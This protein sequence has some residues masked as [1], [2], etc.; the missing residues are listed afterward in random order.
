MRT[1]W[2]WTALLRRLHKY[3]VKQ[4]REKIILSP[5]IQN[6]AI[7]LPPGLQSTVHRLQICDLI[8]KTPSMRLAQTHSTNRPKRRAE[9][10]QD[11]HSRRSFAECFGVHSSKEHIQL[12]MYKF[13]LQTC[14][15]FPLDDSASVSTPS[16]CANLLLDL[17]AGST[18]FASISLVHKLSLFYIGIDLSG[19]NV[20]IPDRSDRL[21]CD[22][23]RSSDLQSSTTLPLR[24]DSVDVI[25]SISFL[26]WLTASHKELSGVI[27]HFFSEIHRILTPVGHC[28]IQFYPH[29]IQELDVVCQ[30]MSTLSP[31][32]SGCRIYARPVSDR[33]VKIFL[34]TRRTL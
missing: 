16:I 2:P 9:S 1:R 14:L 22:L 6:S 12:A 11:L 3:E 21:I 30:A 15:N 32:L 20:S 25:L 29:S 34:Y 13:A 18:G 24:D 5:L 27:D 19:R 31:N 26:Q 23:S 10:L 8:C 28:I 17:G 33:G 7:C 4:D